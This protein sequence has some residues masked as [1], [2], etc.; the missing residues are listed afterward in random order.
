VGNPY[1]ESCKQE[2]GP[3]Y[4]CKSYSEERKA[5]L[6]KLEAQWIANLQ[7]P[8]WIKGE[9][10]KGTPPE[11]TAIFRGLWGIPPG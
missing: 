7:D 8:E 10:R 5:E 11:V 6:R 4:I 2:H 1:C 3:L 9:L